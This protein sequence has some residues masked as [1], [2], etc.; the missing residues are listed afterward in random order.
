MSIKPI[1]TFFTLLLVL[2]VIGASQFV[3]CTSGESKETAAL[4]LA[5]E[6]SNADKIARGHYLVDLCG[7]H[8]CHSPKIFAPEGTSLD[9]SR[10]LSG[11]PE[12]ST[13]PPLDE[14][15]FT[16]GY[17]VMFS[18]NLSAYVG[19]WG[20]TYSA[21]ITPDSATGIGAWSEQ[22]FVKAL[23]T[24]KHQGKEG[25]RQILPPMPWG[26]FGKMTEED[27][28]SMYAYLR[29]IPAVKNKVPAPVAPYDKKK[30]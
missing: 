11:H 6:P 1:L 7:C 4:S 16:P 22:D 2:F 9:S 15:S 3:S 12:G 13:L 30:S 18:P 28:R 5:N 24:G 26:K 29:L 21:N 23:Q 19:T 25:G 17:W 27:L 20:I 10:L 8:D 14:R